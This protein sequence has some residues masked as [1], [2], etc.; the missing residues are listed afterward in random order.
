MQADLIY[1]DVFAITVDSSF[2]GKEKE[3]PISFRI[4]HKVEILIYSNKHF[5]HRQ[6]YV[7]LPAFLFDE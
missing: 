2:T 3:N 5:Y 4:S 6:P 7:W 1:Q